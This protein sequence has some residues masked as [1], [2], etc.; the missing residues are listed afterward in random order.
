[1]S[2]HCI[3]MMNVNIIVTPDSHP[4]P[5]DRCFN[6][7]HG[8]SALLF[9]DIPCVLVRSVHS[10]SSELR[11]CSLSSPS[12][13]AFQ[14]IISLLSTFSDGSKLLF[15]QMSIKIIKVL[16]TVFLHD[17]TSVCINR[18]LTEVINFC[19]FSDGKPQHK[20]VEYFTFSFG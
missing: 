4:S 15:N 18:F 20:K 17:I 9:G 2:S 8:L 7:P 6:R 19:Y 10:F 14:R 11:F 5:R 12:L 1:M 16:K 13:A 3:G